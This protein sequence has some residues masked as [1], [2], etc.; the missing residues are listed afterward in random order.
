MNKKLLI[1]A[2][3]AVPLAALAADDKWMT[4]RQSKMASSN[5]DAAAK[6]LAGDERRLIPE[7]LTG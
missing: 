2:C 7:C 6:P 5:K 3:I 4:P 1:A